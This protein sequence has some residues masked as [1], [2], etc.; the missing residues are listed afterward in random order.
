MFFNQDCFLNA[1][2]FKTHTS[3]IVLK[4]QIEESAALVF[5]RSDDDTATA[6]A[7]LLL[8]FFKYKSPLTFYKI[9]L[10][11]ICVNIARH[12]FV[13]KRRLEEEES[14]LLGIFV[15]TLGPFFF[16]HI[17]SANLRSQRESS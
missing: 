8:F 7:L 12:Y 10:Q 5:W 16:H 14:F 4:S 1:I 3:S 9:A 15:L 11:C 6:H 17:P 13:R 2:F